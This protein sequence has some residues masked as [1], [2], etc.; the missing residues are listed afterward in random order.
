MNGFTDEQVL[1]IRRG[2]ATDSKL[3]A[4]VALAADITK[5][6]GKL[7]AAKRNWLN[8]TS[9]KILFYI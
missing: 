4:L 9:N 7:T 8:C 2:K 3:N 5:N 1:D 6:K